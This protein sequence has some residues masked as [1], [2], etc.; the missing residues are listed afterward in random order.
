MA[1]YIDRD[2]LKCGIVK[3]G[4]AEDA[5]RTLLDWNSGLMKLVML[6]IDEIPAADVEPVRHGRWIEYPYAHY[7]KCSECKCPVPYK[8]AVLT[9]GK[10]KYNYCPNCGAKMIEGENNG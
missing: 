2:A 4:I 10:R 8:K 6:E 5:L 9:N 3:R 7:F 1:E